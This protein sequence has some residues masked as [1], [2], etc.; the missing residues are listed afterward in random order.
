M[1]T[2]LILRNRLTA[3]SL[4]EIALALGIITFALVGI[5]GLFPV[6]VGAATDSQQETQAAL[7]ARSIFNQLQATPDTS[8]RKVT[9]GDSYDDSASA[10]INLEATADT[11]IG[12]DVDGNP[13]SNPDDPKAVYS[14]QIRVTPTSELN[15]GSYPDYETSRVLILVTPIRSPERPIRFASILQQHRFQY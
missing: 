14:V 13:L 1:K 5:V 7:I 9:T 15:P 11:T 6:A 8:T 10:E 12:Y 3:F 4:I 2:R